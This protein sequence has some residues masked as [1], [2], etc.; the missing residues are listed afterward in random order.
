MAKM[1][2]PELQEFSWYHC[3]GEFNKSLVIKLHNDSYWTMQRVEFKLQHG[4]WISEPPA[5]ILPK[6]TAF[7]FAG[8]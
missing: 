2:D 7:F 1:M 3:T 5:T 8:I 6:E 4:H